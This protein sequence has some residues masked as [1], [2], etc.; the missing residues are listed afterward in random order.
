[1]LKEF[2]EFISRGDLV[3]LAVAVILGLSLNTVV[4]SL[5]TDVISPLIAA[6]FGQPDF[7]DIKIDVGNSEIFIGSFLNALIYFVMVAFVLFLIIKAYNRALPKEEKPGEP[8]ERELLTQ[9]RDA[10]SSR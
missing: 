6:V 1:M 2:K 9:I 4:Q 7:S 10:L 8:T 5:V 3:E